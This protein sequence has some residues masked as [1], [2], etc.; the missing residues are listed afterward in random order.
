[1]ITETIFDDLIVSLNESF[2]EITV[3][4]KCLG[5]EKRMKIILKLL[6]GAHSYG[7]IVEELNLKK[8]AVSNH[9]S[10]LL[11]T[12]LI[13]KDD[14]GVYSISGDGIE[15][16]KA[17]IKAYQI[18]PTRQIKRFEDLQRRSVTS[19]FLNRFSP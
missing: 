1:M 2:Q 19:S 9:L 13:R 3:I 10:Q 8:T 18:S 16:I 5:N 11:K 7:S 15:F 4:L 14:Y 12:N 17:I 6:K